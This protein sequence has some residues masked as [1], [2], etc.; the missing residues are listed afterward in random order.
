KAALIHGDA[1]LSYA[2]FSAAIETCRRFLAR[3]ALLDRG[4][5]VVLSHELAD[6]WVLVM[7]LRAQGFDTISLRSIGQAEAL[8]LEDVACVAVTEAEHRRL[9]LR[10]N[11]IS[12]DRMVVLPGLASPQLHAGDGPPVRLEDGHFGGHLLYTSGTTGDYKKVLLEGE[13]EEARN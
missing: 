12:P 6:A 1:V 13:H 3:R 10:S 9:D 5:A 11:T 4:I 2:A 7:A 8:G